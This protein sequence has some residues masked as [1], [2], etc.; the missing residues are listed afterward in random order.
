M[1]PAKYRTTKWKSWFSN[2]GD[3]N[4]S[5]KSA[6]GTKGSPMK[7]CKNRTTMKKSWV[8]DLH[9][10][11]KKEVLCKVLKQTEKNSWIEGQRKSPEQ[12]HSKE[13]GALRPRAL[14][15]TERRAER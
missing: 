7:C 14:K 8:A 2:R 3:K 11:H 6:L 12:K 5:S 10:I 1:R 4:K 9:K 13:E 15:I